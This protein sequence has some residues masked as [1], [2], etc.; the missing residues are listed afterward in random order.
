MAA[1]HREATFLCDCFPEGG[2]GEISMD[3]SKRTKEL[4]M[5]VPEVRSIGCEPEARQP[6]KTKGNV[7]NSRNQGPVVRRPISV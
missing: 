3:T 2:L 7:Q 1:A 5:T 4:P 6:I